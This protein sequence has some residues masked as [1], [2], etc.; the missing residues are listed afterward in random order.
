L[1]IIQAFAM[2]ELSQE[3][4]TLADIARPGNG[5]GQGFWT[6]SRKA[7]AVFDPSLGW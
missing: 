5:Q 2:Q 1:L 7:L 3:S 4:V 6:F